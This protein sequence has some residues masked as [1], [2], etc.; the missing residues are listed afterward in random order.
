MM[1]AATVTAGPKEN[2]LICHIG[3][4][5]GPGGETY[6]DDSTCVPSRQNGYFCPDAGKVD[7]IVVATVSKHLG[8]PKHAYDGLSDYKPADVGAG[9][10]STEDNNGNGIDDGCEP[11]QECPC[12]AESELLSVTAENLSTDITLNSCSMG[13]VLPDFAAIQNVPGSTPGVEGGFAAQITGAGAFCLTR[14]IDMSTVLITE[15]EAYACI[16]QVVARCA[17]IGD[18]I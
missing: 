5:E 1:F 13:S 7:L 15:E 14:D 6:L 10:D 8:N 4:K 11:L 16:A 12:W 17:A 18:P 2:V 9:G 3:S